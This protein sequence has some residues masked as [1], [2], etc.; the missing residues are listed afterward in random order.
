MKAISLQKATKNYPST[1]V[2]TGF[3]VSDVGMGG[4]GG[5]WWSPPYFCAQFIFF[6]KRFITCF[7][8]EIKF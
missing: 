4:G 7:V 8:L 5:F 3:T 6:T 1:V 2:Y